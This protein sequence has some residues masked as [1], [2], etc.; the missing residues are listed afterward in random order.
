MHAS[1]TQRV[2]TYLYFTDTYLFL[3]VFIMPDIPI[4]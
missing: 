4:Q 2:N 3:I 1:V